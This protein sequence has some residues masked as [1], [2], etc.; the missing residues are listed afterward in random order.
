M[1]LSYQIK[2]MFNDLKLLFKKQGYLINWKDIEKQNIDQ[3]LILFLWH[4]HFLWK[5]NK[6]CGNK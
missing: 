2:T 5:K 1:K 3:I 4:H 6:F